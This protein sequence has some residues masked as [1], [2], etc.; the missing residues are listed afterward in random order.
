MGDIP[1]QNGS[2]NGRTLRG[3]GNIDSQFEHVDASNEDALR[4]FTERV[5]ARDLTFLRRYNTR[6]N[7]RFVVAALL[8]MVCCMTERNPAQQARLFSVISTNL[9][10]VGA[11]P[12]SLLSNELYTI[13][14]KFYLTLQRLIRTTQEYLDSP[15]APGDFST[16]TR[17]SRNAGDESQ[18]RRIFYDPEGLSLS[19]CR[20]EYFEL[21]QLGKGGFGKV[22]LDKCDC[23]VYALKKV[24]FVNL[25]HTTCLKILREVKILARLVHPNIVHYYGAWLDFEKDDDDSVLTETSSCPDLSRQN[26]DF[27][28]H[29]SSLGL[30]RSESSLDVVFARSSNEQNAL[31][32]SDEEPMVNHSFEYNESEEEHSSQSE[33]RT[34]RL[35]GSGTLCLCIRMELCSF[36]LLEWISNRN[37]EAEKLKDMFEAVNPVQ[38]EYILVQLIEA[39]RYVHS[40]RIIHRDI[41]PA[42]IFLNGLMPRVML[43]DFGLA[44]GFDEVAIGDSEDIPTTSTAGHSVGVGTYLYAAPEQLNTSTYNDRVDVYSLGVVALEMF[45]P[46]RTYMERI[47]CLT[48]LRHGKVVDYFEERWPYVASLIGKMVRQPAKLRPSSECLSRIGIIALKEQVLMELKMKRNALVSDLKGASLKLKNCCC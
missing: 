14:Q 9:A 7:M 43:G 38:C 35:F 10:N 11:I 13:R 18:E 20:D 26:G 32:S 17:V 46:F 3:R 31:L 8:E 28:L 42:N 15:T 24:D 22:V 23:R 45:L 21:S 40:Q 37:E 39:V 5:M 36:T 30:R 47:V 12:R 1:R 25:H 27:S 6:D 2:S 16:A 34:K 29:D 33:R 4:A 48:N 41:K 44:C 19:R